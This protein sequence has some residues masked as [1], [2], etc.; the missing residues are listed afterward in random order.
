MHGLALNQ[1]GTLFQDWDAV[2]Y[3]LLVMTIVINTV[4]SGPMVA[5]LMKKEY[6]LFAHSHTTLG[7]ELVEKPENELRVL[8]CV[9]GPRQVS[10]VLSVIATLRGPQ[11][12]PIMPY[13]AHLIELQQKRRTNVSY[14]EL[15]DDELSDEDEYGGNDVVEIHGAVD[16]FTK[17]TTIL[18]TT[19]KAVSTLPFLYEDVCT[20]AEDLRATIILLPFHK[21]QRI[22][23]KMES[24]KE[25]VRTTN[26]K[27]L[28]H[29][30]SSVGIVVEKGLAGAVGFAQLTRVDTVQ[31]V[32]TLFFG[33]PDDREAIA[34]STRI[35]NHPRINLTVIR[36]LPSESSNTRNMR[37]ES[38]KGNNDIEVFMALSSLEM[39]NDIDNA[40]LNDF[41]NGY[42]PLL[43]M[44]H[45]ADIN[46]NFSSTYTYTSEKE[47]ICTHIHFSILK[48]KS[49]Y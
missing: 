10:A 33:G 12:A 45:F 25:A 31:H 23:G 41:Y 39:G 29:A 8:G 30:P 7:T 11:T 48:K 4:I 44:L 26:Q 1:L 38:E 22:D 14:H 24:G 3:N 36:F 28:R 35:A 37:V 16:A 43:I 42:V 17:E 19:I 32:A 15:E 47:S 34:W 46:Q 2:A 27:I 9:Y 5:V 21:H 18:I 6:Q 40:F 49:S 20:A 13:L